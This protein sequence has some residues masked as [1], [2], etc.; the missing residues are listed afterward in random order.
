MKD[1]H[2]DVGKLDRVGAGA[3]VVGEARELTAANQPEVILDGIL[4]RSGVGTKPGGV[5][6]CAMRD[7]LD[8][9]VGRVSVVLSIS[10]GGVDQRLSWQRA[11]DVGS[12]L[13]LDVENGEVAGELDHSNVLGGGVE[14]LG[15]AISIDVGEK[16]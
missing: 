12:P 8:V 10:G 11:I 6:G 2:T 13:V 3:A 5:S 1:I 9:S 4:A 15:V 14:V 7:T 16:V